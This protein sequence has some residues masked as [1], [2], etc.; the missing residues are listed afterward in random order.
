MGFHGSFMDTFTGIPKCIFCK[1]KWVFIAL[2]I[3][4]EHH[5]YRSVMQIYMGFHGSFMNAFTGMSEC[6]SCKF[7]WV[8]MVFFIGFEHQGYCSVYDANFNGF[9]QKF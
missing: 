3:G 6:K 1:F 2:S 8:F 4:F 5:E 9:S 7:K